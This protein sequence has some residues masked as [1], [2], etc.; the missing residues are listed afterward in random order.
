M[1]REEKRGDRKNHLIL[2]LSRRV[3]P[4]RPAA[5]VLELA[6]ALTEERIERMEDQKAELDWEL[7]YMKKMDPKE[8]EE[9]KES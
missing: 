8:L 6:I 3:R 2:Q 5:K 1:I 9:E 7:E 4:H